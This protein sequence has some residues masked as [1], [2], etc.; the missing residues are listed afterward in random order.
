M[1]NV[2]FPFCFV[3]ELNTISSRLTTFHTLLNDTAFQLVKTVCHISSLLEGDGA[4]E[5]SFTERISAFKPDT[6]KRL[7]KLISGTKGENTFKS[8][9]ADAKLADNVAS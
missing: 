2:I 5:S 1:P 7:P 6:T 9:L 8:P 4:S 3:V